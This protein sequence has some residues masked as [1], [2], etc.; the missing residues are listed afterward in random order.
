M[1]RAPTGL[2][3]RRIEHVN[4]ARHEQHH[5]DVDHEAVILG[6][7]DAQGLVRRHEG[8]VVDEKAGGHTATPHESRSRP[9]DHGYHEHQRRRR[10][11]EVTS[12][13]QHRGAQR[14]DAHHSDGDPRRRLCTLSVSYEPVEPM[15]EC[16]EEK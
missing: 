2:D 6:G 1:I 5:H 9:D 16:N 4:D 14:E 12:Q 15:G 11:T 13:R 3:S 10:D 8:V 7:T